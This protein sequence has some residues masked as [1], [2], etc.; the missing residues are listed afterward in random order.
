[1][2]RAPADAVQIQQTI[3]VDIDP[4]GLATGAA[5]ERGHL[6]IGALDEASTV[7]RQELVVD[8]ERFLL[9]LTV[10]AAPTHEQVDVAVSVVIR[11]CQPVTIAQRKDEAMVARVYAPGAYVDAIE[12]HGGVEGNGHRQ[13]ATR[14][15][16]DSELTVPP[17]FEAQR[18]LR[19][20]TPRPVADHLDRP[21]AR[22]ERRPRATRDVREELRHHPRLR[23]SRTGC[24]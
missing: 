24:A 22:A 3:G 14:D 21:A 2:V 17:C 10:R 5:S 15:S 19:S 18:E 11:P 1:M 6:L 20:D 13:A 8:V 23:R 4:G 16:F 12:I 9:D 7:L